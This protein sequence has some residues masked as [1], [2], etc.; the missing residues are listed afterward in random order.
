MSELYKMWIIACIAMVQ[1]SGRILSTVNLNYCFVIN[2]HVTVLGNYPTVLNSAFE[3]GFKYINI[4]KHSLA[5]AP[6]LMSRHSVALLS[7]N[8]A[9]YSPSL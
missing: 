4:V 9:T 3:V 7:I 1:L 5:S 2:C 6:G 8:P